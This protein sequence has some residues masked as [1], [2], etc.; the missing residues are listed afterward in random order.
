MILTTEHEFTLPR[1]YLDPDSGEVHRQVI[2]RLA[3]GKDDYQASVSPRV[4]KNPRYKGIEVLSRVVLRVG[5]IEHVSAELIRTLLAIDYYALIEEYNRLNYGR[6]PTLRWPEAQAWSVESEPIALAGRYLD[7]SGVERPLTAVMRA[8]RA[9]DEVLPW[10]DERV[11]RHPA[12]RPY[13]VLARVLTRLSGT[14]AINPAV[15]QELTLADLQT[16]WR[17]YNHL[18]FGCD[19]FPHQSLGESLATPLTSSGGR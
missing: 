17:E 6:P 12:F 10:G 7:E 18:N 8:A 4:A 14:T 16:L 11:Q 1:G 3:T 15:M 5:A 9:E 13:I 19:P 2:L